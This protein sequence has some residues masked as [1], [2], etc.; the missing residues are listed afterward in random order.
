MLKHFLIWNNTLNSTDACNKLEKQIVLG[1]LIYLGL[2][3]FVSSRKADKHIKKKPIKHF[4]L[5][6]PNKQSYK[7]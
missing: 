5:K 1:K 2:E 6:A 7:T 3:A 4:H